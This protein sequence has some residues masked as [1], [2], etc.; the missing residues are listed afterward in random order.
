[1]MGRRLRLRGGDE[2]DVVTGWRRVLH[3]RAGEVKKIKR[4]MNRRERKDGRRECK[5]YR[6]A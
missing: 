6:Q 4:K 2:W 1:M 5:A 3:W